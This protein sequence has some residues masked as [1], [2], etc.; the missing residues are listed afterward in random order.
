MPVSPAWQSATSPAA[1]RRS[2]PPGSSDEAMAIAALFRLLRAGFVVARE[3]GLSFVDPDALPAGPRTVVR[4]ARLVERPAASARDRGE[5]LT[6]ALNKLG[7]SYVK[8]GQF[9]AT[10][11]DIVGGEM[12][13]ALG[14]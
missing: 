14:A 6:A 2:I 11:P 8:L 12:A 10:R 4:L 13:D 7:P 5:R 9:L 1:L 3:G